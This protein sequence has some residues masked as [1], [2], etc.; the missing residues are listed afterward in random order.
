MDQPQSPTTKPTLAEVLA[1]D[2]PTNETVWLS[3]DEID[4]SVEADIAT[5]NLLR[6]LTDF[7]RGSALEAV[8]MQDVLTNPDLFIALNMPAR[9]FINWFRRE[10]WHDFQ[11]TITTGNDEWAWAVLD[12]ARAM[13]ADMGKLDLQVPLRV[14]AKI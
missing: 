4:I 11:L 6:H 3:L 10:D 8:A 2:D 9:E 14:P 13:C 1:M 5:T 7:E 12:R